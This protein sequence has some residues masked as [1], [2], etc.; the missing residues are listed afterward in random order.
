V[1]DLLPKDMN[2]NVNHYHNMSDAQLLARA[3]Q[4]DKLA[5]PFLE[6]AL[7]DGRRRDDKLSRKRASSLD[8]GRYSRRAAGLDGAAEWL[9]HVFKDE[10]KNCQ[11]NT[12]KPK[13]G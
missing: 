2:L 10:N 5:G 11:I 13:K 12:K 7:I 1:A 4:V 9:R 3:R 8:S 6:M